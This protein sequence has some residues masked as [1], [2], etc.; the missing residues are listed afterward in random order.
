MDFYARLG[1]KTTATADEIRRAYRRLALKLHPDRNPQ[2]KDAEGK[3]REIGE[4]YETLADSDRRVKYDRERSAPPPPPPAPP[5]NYPVANVVVEVGINAYDHKNGAQKT[6]TV[7]KPRMCPDCG[8]T[9][10]PVGRYLGP[11]QLCGGLGCQP[12]GWTGKLSCAR[13][14]GR[15]QDRDTTTITVLIPA[16]VTPY[17][18]ARLV[19][20]GN[21]WGLRGPFYI[22]ANIRFMVPRP[23]LIV[24]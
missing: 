12:C 11:C 2:D 13:C 24:R 10:H 7:S 6:V 23:G 22:D 17:G 5:P 4:A 9:G 20:M 21:L 18:R 8:G 1:V 16:G 19:A 14:W 15:G 3:F